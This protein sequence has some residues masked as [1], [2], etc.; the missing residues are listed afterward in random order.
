MSDPNNCRTCCCSSKRSQSPMVR[1]EYVPCRNPKNQKC[2]FR[3]SG[4]GLGNSGSGSR[5]TPTG[6]ESRLILDPCNWGGKGYRQTWFMLRMKAR[7]SR[8]EA[9]KSDKTQPWLPKGAANAKILAPILISRMEA[10]ALGP[11][12]AKWNVNCFFFRAAHWCNWHP[13]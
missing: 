7:Y 8:A 4:V 6:P 13:R 1:T 11:L 10:M 9:P 3:P 5:L 2:T 12:W